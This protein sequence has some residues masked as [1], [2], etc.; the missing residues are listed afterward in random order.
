[1]SSQTGIHNPHEHHAII[2]SH[3]KVKIYSSH[4]NIQPR[5]QITGVEYTII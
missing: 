3:S 2:K 1:M 4:S 5:L